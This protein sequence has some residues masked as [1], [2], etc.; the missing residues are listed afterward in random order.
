MTPAI[1]PVLDV[2]TT[3]DIDGNPWPTAVIDATDH[4]EVRDLPRVHATEGIGDIRTEA[5]RLPTEEGDLLLL[6]VRVTRPVLCAFALAFSLDAQ[7]PI[8]EQAAEAGHL[9][10]ATTPPTS[11]ADDQPLWLAIDLDPDALRTAIS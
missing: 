3:I 2:G 7:R 9:M 1:F 5:L 8:L 11:V 4:P 6:G 10:V